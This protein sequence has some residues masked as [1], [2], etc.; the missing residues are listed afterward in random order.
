MMLGDLIA[1]LTDE[2]DA[3]SALESLGDIVLFAEVRKMGE[4]W[5]ET[6]A[7]YLAGSA[8]RFAATAGDEDWLGLMAEMERADDPARAAL[9]RMLRWALVRDAAEVAG[10][11]HQ[12]C[13]GGCG[14]HA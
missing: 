10:K 12:H 14:G 3:T 2:D 7:A 6:P 8:R 5:A 13:Q 9:V 1:R 11:G 4:F